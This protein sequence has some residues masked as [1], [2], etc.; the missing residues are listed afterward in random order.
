MIKTLAAARARIAQ[1]PLARRF[2]G[3]AAWGVAGAVVYSFINLVTM[4]FVARLLG[5]ETYGEFII[6]QS[7]LGMVGVFAG[8][9]IGVTATRYV[10][11]LRSRDAGRLVRI[12]ALTERAVLAFGF[13]ATV[14]LVLISGII[15]STV[16]NTPGLSLPL[17]IAAF[18]VF[19]LA[20]DG[21]QK[22]V[23]IG[24]EAMRAFAIGTVVAAAVSVPIM[25]VLADM[26]GLNGVASAMA[27]S[28]LIQAGI[29]RFQMSG[30]L[31]RNAIR[32]E[33]RGCMSEWRVLRDFALPALL[34]GVL[35]VPAHWICQAMLANTSNGYAELAVL[36][37]AM[38]WFNVILFLPSVSGRVVLPILTEHLSDKNHLDA[39]RLL[40]FS[41]GA[42]AVVTVPIAILAAV[43]SSWIL[44]LY[45]A[46]FQNGSITMVIAVITASLVSIQ[47][48]VGNMIAAVS[49][50]WLAALMNFSWALVY[51]GLAYTLIVSGYGSAGIAGAMGIAY[52]VHT[53][54]LFSFAKKQLNALNTCL[55]IALK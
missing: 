12:L 18:S 11:K 27:I 39:K 44:Q 51:V 2:L 13:I 15:A 53:I 4:M 6:M 45:G 1:S 30:Q 17:S 24:L 34:S 38:Q 40:L 29:S 46:E 48:P 49:R 47:T 31:Q 37:V 33:A 23:L 52:L 3:G 9:G 8:F 14:V 5:K 28:A 32:R 21:Y 55:P 22:S 20:L 42:N 7:T 43:F 50:M 19:F 26:Y 36:G 25:L 54:H 35:V 16:L 10:A 41:I